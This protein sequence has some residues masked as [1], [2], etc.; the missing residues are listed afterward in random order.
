M[1]R[2]VAVTI[3]T[4]A[5]EDVPG[6]MRTIQAT[7]LQPPRPAEPRAEFWLDRVRPDLSRAWGA[8]DGGTCVGSLRTLPFELTVPG[9]RTVPADGVTAV[10]VASTH[11][12]RGILTGLMAEGL[13]AAADRGDPVSI[14][15]AAEWRIYGRYGFGVATEDAT[16]E[17]DRARAAAGPPLGP[18]E[19]VEI[20]E[21]R[22]LAPPV[23]DA[24]RRDRPG[25]I[26]RP[27]PRW[28]LDFGLAHA[29]GEQPDWSGRAVV[30]RDP[31]G[32]VDGYLR[33]HADDSWDGMLPTGTLHV[34]ELVTTSREAYADLWRFA[35]GV[36]LI[37][38]VRASDRP[39][40]EPLPWL[41]AD[42]RAALQVQ[43]W[44]RLWLRPLDVPATLTGRGYLG[45]GRVV[46]EVVDPAGY[47]AG[48]FALDA[49]PDG[50]D[51]RPTTQGADLTVPADVLGAAYLGGTRLRRLA[52]AGLVDEH[53]PGAVETA[54]RLL[55]GDQVPYLPLHF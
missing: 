54:D 32:E 13:R 1:V 27:E 33:W 48:R 28:D 18:V 21:L 30:R 51:C 55:A 35:L 10:T 49:G 2:G 17:V 6:F 15:I 53:R 46:V 14:L 24:A 20:G 9:G 29:E 39:L 16:W 40:D 44:D 12:R 23:Y 38:K 36:D 25:G 22:K 52:G 8:F 31:A 37:A 26:D 7:F 50:A 5:R 43:R 45:T 47:A 34:D 3:R 42:G 41:L 19:A 11:R 4:L